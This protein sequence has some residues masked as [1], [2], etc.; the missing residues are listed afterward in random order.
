M[1]RNFLIIEI[2]NFQTILVA[3]SSA[4]WIPVVDA[5]LHTVT[6]FLGTVG[7][8]LATAYYPA[9]VPHGCLTV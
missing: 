3:P 7:E 2:E 9:D 6:Q 4:V 8:L 1:I 5:A